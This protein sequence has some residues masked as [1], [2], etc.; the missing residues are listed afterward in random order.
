MFDTNS[1]LQ[2]LNQDFLSTQMSNFDLVKNPLESGFDW[3]HRESCMDNLIISDTPNETLLGSVKNN[4]MLGLSSGHYLNGKQGDD[5]IFGLNSNNTLIGSSGNDSLYVNVGNNILKGA[6]GND[7][8][9]SGTGDDCLEGGSDRDILNAGGGND[10]LIDVNGGDRLAGGEGSDQFE[11][12][13]GEF[14]ATLVTDFHPEVDKLKFTQLGITFEQLTFNE[15]ASG[16]TVIQ[17]QGQ[18]L[19]ELL[20]I[21][22]TELTANNFLFGN[23]E[24]ANTL[25]ITLNQTLRTTVSPGATVAIRTPDGY[26][27][28]GASGLSNLETNAAAAASDRFNIGSVTKTFTGVTV[29]Q[30]VEEKQLGLEDT[31]TKWL[32]QSITDNILNSDRITIR[33]LLSMTSGI[34]NADPFTNTP[35]TGAY[36]QDLFKDPSLIFK[37]QTPKEFLANYV[38]GRQPV[39]APGTSFDYNNSNYRLLGLIIESATGS[40]LAEAY[41]DQI[42]EPLGLKDTF[43]ADVE[44]SSD[45]YNPGY[46]DLNQDGQLENLR[47]ASLLESGASGG[48]ISNV[49][50][51]TRFAQGLFTGEL[52][53]P[54]AFNELITG[55]GI[56][57]F[58]LGIAYA[59]TP[60]QG[61]VYI[62]NGTG[63]GVQTQLLY[64]EQTG[65]TG[66]VI[67]NGDNNLF[68]ANN[69]AAT[70]LSAIVSSG[71]G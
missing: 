51:L 30:L 71:L 40:T 32:P 29:M 28:E 9:W 15:Q 13:Q 10:T 8:L 60:E 49:E 69:P 1:S 70:I 41:Q 2:S 17:F 63:F 33:Q 62:T 16:S 21:Q 43:L 46:A 5:R 27:W 20:C 34:Y 57:G 45:R 47:A 6:S 24:L 67:T 54:A 37:N 48:L 58:G 42:I 11:I 14:G 36:Y 66:A 59:D 4:W 7:W 23:A 19:A 55:S 53:S 61:R 52:L 44:N 68:D 12:Y 31:M 3:N 22:P 38:Y 26:L 50:D 64:S 25:Q 35:E 18:D 56:P 39:F 65:A